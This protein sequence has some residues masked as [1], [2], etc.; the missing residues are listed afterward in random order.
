M[1]QS[2]SPPS[3]YP[4]LFTICCLKTCRELSKAVTHYD[5][6]KLQEGD[7]GIYL[8]RKTQAI[9]SNNTECLLWG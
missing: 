4:V 7:L 1:H 9:V 6:L 3:W 8:G 5:H 2:L